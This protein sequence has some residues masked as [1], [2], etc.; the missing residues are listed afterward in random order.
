MNPNMLGFAN[1]YSSNINLTP[2]PL[3][4]SEK[5]RVPY[6]DASSKIRGNELDN[7]ANVYADA[8]N[9]LLDVNNSKGKPCSLKYKFYKGYKNKPEEEV[10]VSVSASGGLVK[11]NNPD[12]D[13][14]EITLF[15]FFNNEESTIKQLECYA[16]KKFPTATFS[17]KLN[18]TSIFLDYDT[19]NVNIIEGQN[20]LLLLDKK[21]RPIKIW[22]YDNQNRLTQYRVYE[23]SDLGLLRIDS[24]NIIWN[25]TKVKEI[26]YRNHS[27]KCSYDSTGNILKV[28]NY[29][30]DKLTMVYNYNYTYDLKFNWLTFELQEFNPAK[31][32]RTRKYFVKREILYR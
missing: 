14:E 25:D 13:N 31:N 19:L 21:K 9:I 29:I 30:A 22:S 4:Y 20:Q 3:S 8:R 7:F 32:S 23:Y 17:A 15:S 12:N 24:T 6:L 27:T 28:E 18:E 2:F 26:N 10:S 1:L 16:N 5:L 11:Q